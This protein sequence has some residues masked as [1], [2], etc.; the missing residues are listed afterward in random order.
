[1]VCWWHCFQFFA[2]LEKCC[3]KRNLNPWGEKRIVRVFFS[4]FLYLYIYILDSLLKLQ[5]LVF[6]VTRESF[7]LTGSGSFVTVYKWLVRI[8]CDEVM[9][10]EEGRVWG[11]NSIYIFYVSNFDCF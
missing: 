10:L 3:V 5:S 7:L 6:K 1:M 4:F 8:K 11:A 2:V 9:Q